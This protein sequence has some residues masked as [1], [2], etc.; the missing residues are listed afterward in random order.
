MSL[1]IQVLIVEKNKMEIAQ[2]IYNLH[3]ATYAEVLEN[4]NVYFEFS[5]IEVDTFDAIVNVFKAENL[6]ITTASY[7]MLTREA[8]AEVEP[9]DS[10]IQYMNLIIASHPENF[11][12]YKTLS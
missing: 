11:P 3:N 12:T 7:I 2:R 6:K 5:D 4:G 10:F 9:I 8:I 1:F